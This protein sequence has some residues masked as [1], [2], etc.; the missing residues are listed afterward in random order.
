MTHTSRP[1]PTGPGAPGRGPAGRGAPGR[2]KRSRAR[3]ALLVCA[4]VLAVA[5]LAG[6]GLA[7]FAYIKLS[8]NLSSVDLDAKLGTDRP[9]DADNGS[10]DILVLG[11]DSRSGANAKYGREGGA[12]SD[13]AMVVHL[14]QDRTK[15]SVVSIPRDTL[16]SRPSCAGEDGTAVPAATR[17]MFNS[18]Y[19]VGGPACA[20]KTVEAMTGLRMDHFVE[21]DF[22]GFK[23]LVD[24]LGGVEVTTTEA[25]HDRDSHLDLAAGTHTLDGEQALGLVRTRHGIG[26]GSDLGR[27]GLQQTFVKAL[28]DQVR[29]LGLLSSPTKLYGLADTATSALTTDKGLASIPELMGL[30]TSLKSLSAG[31]LAMVTLPVTADPADPN[32]VVPLPAE[33]AQVWKALKTDAPLPASATDPPTPAR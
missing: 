20:V 18:A 14:Y 11:S 29:D 2:R 8:G 10:L 16:V 6:G 27:I 5:L 28:L 12:R 9:A 24:G 1:D 15:A 25:I 32:R 30:A 19:A 17:V 13:T 3:T 31:N 7:A 33:S 26:D 21:V 23:K 22:T 4:C